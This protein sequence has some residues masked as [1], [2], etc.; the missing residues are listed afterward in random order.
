MNTKVILSFLLIISLWWACSSPTEEKNIQ[1]TSQAK[2]A[3]KP[4][5]GKDDKRANKT[6][7]K[8]REKIDLTKIRIDTAGK[9]T[10]EDSIALALYEPIKSGLWDTLR[11]IKYEKEG[12]YG[13]V[14]LFTAKHKP[15]HGKYVRV[16]G[17]M[18]PIE[19]TE[20]QKWFMLS[21]FPSSSC[22]FC[23]AAGPETAIEVKSPKGVMYKRD[24]RITLR[25]KLFL[26]YDEPERLFYILEE[27]V[28]E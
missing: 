9:Y 22:F 16:E 13:H 17:Y 8:E 15:L 3:G 24:K 6:T 4:E 21:Y 1:K 11:D 20:L 19:S 7:E 10:A 27:A 23:G 5:V 2:E 26:N 18:H 25:G 12:V 28:Q 14:P